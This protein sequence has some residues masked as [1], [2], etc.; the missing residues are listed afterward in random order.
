MLKGGEERS[1]KT[2]ILVAVLC[3]IVSTIHVTQGIWKS[4]WEDFL[5]GQVDVVEVTR[6]VPL[7]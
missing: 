5:G 1:R 6:T 7:E 2:L 3:V 4:G